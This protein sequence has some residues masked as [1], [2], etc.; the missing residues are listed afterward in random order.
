MLQF[1]YIRQSLLALGAASV[2]SRHGDVWSLKRNQTL[3]H[4]I[5]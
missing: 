3:V 5:G 1:D 2:W 4:S